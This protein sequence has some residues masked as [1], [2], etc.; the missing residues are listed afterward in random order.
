MA[1]YLNIEFGFW[2]FSGIA[3]F[4]GVFAVVIRIIFG[5]IK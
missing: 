1:N 2:V 4:V 5:A 3:G